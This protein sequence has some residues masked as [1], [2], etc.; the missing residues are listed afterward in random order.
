MVSYETIPA[1]PAAED[2]LL[3]KPKPKVSL[4]RVIGAAAI[5]SFI[6]GAVAA[7]ALSMP[8]G[9]PQTRSPSMPRLIIKTIYICWMHSLSCS[10]TGSSP[11]VIWIRTSLKKLTKPFTRVLE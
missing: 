5:T 4:K 2:G 6:L 7:T 1:D 3:A 10:R 9:V 8:A 11:F